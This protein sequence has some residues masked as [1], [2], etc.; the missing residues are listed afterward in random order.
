MNPLFPILNI[1][2][3]IKEELLK[4]EAV[5][6]DLSETSDFFHVRAIISEL[7]E[8]HGFEVSPYIPMRSMI[9]ATLCGLR[10]RSFDHRDVI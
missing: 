3:R 7:I 9:I 1:V 5:R 4:I 6:S 2:L 8:T 10:C